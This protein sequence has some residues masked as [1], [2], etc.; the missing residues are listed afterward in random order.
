MA[1]KGSLGFGEIRTDLNPGH[2]QV[3]VA[4]R[5]EEGNLGFN[6]NGWSSQGVTVLLGGGCCVRCGFL[7]L[8]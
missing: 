6:E 1:S 7:V 8:K 4:N 3:I 5:A 2:F